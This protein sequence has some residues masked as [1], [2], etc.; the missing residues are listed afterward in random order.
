AGFGPTVW[1]INNRDEHGVGERDEG[2]P[3]GGR[4]APQIVAQQ[5][6]GYDGIDQA[7]GVPHAGDKVET[8]GPVWFW[9]QKIMLDEFYVRSA[10]ARSPQ[11]RRRQVQAR[12]SD[13]R[14]RGREVAGAAG[15]VEPMR[16]WLEQSRDQLEFVRSVG[17][18]QR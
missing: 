11:H 2:Y 15:D 1:Q 12:S 14:Q 7:V 3:G 8:I 18:R 9:H 16:L 17:G 5:R 10:A 13:L 4:P 6:H